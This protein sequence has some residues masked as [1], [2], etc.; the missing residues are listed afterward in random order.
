MA[1]VSDNLHTIIGEL[2]TS[3]TN[4][5]RE[6]GTSF[7]YV[8]MLLNGKRF[9]ISKTLARLIEELFGYSADWIRKNKGNKMKDW[10][11]AFRKEH[12]DFIENVKKLKPN[13]I[14]LVMEFIDLLELEE[15]K[16]RNE[17]TPKYKNQKK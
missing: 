10:F 1:Y 3:Q 6:I 15:I 9:K 12:P 2:N 17:R 5:A 16:K 7:T 8:N 13:E 14:K 4:F 11:T